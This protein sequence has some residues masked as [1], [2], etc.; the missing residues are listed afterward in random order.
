MKFKITPKF[1]VKEIINST[2]KKDWFEFQDKAFE[3]GQKM[4][5]FIINYI[6]SN[7][8][9]RGGTGKLAKAIN[10]EKA[11]P[12]GT[13]FWGIGNIEILQQKAPYWYVV[14]YG[15]MVG[16]LPFIPNR[17]KFVPGS[18]E[19]T[20]P[21]SALR[22]GVQK[23]NYNDGSGMGMYPKN[24]IRPMNYIQ[25]TRASFNRRLSSLIRS[26]KRRG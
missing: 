20:A 3:L 26:L 1:N 15:K 9:R 14:N 24:P 19:G 17:G 23:F 25:V 6:E 7:H 12:P 11:T 16:G 5:A 13:I 10:L 2:I 8:K 21:A 22:E 4:H 18:F